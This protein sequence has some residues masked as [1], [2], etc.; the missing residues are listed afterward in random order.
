MSEADPW[1]RGLTK[2]LSLVGQ[3]LHPSGD[4]EAWGEHPDS[5]RLEMIEE[6]L[7]T[8]RAERRATDERLSATRADLTETREKLGLAT[9]ELDQFTAALADAK[10]TLGR[11]KATLSGLRQQHEELLESHKQTRQERDELH[12]RLATVGNKLDETSTLKARSHQELEDV[13]ADLEDAR[14]QWSSA[15]ERVLE[16][17]QKLER[18]NDDLRK[19]RREADALLP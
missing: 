8:E 2:A 10:E 1:L 17:D 5:V 13:R 6:A 14:S 4:E 7:A 9:T 19:V 15:K 16:S 18:L 3:E 11:E 12:N